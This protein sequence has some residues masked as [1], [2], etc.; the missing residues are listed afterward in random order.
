[1]IR[2]SCR[3]SSNKVVVL[4]FIL[5]VFLS[6]FISASCSEGQIDVNS[7]GLEE[8]DKLYGIGPTK[9]QAIID[10]READGDFKILEDLINVNGIGEATLESIKSQGLAC[11][12]F[13]E[14]NEEVEESR[15]EEY[16]DNSLNYTE[17]T[18]PSI[19]EIQPILLNPKEDAGKDIK[20]DSVLENKEA[21]SKEH[22]IYFFAGFCI[23]IAGLF[24]GKSIERK[25]KNEFG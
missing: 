1:M 23:L 17:D 11:V 25:N 5:A 8:L 24:L 12:D 18:G 15:A 13:G 7:A 6:S 20:T 3:W 9:A 2:Q 21:G 19:I 16:A 4:V 10:Y 14:E 22:M